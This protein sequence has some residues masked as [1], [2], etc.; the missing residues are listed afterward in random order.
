MQVVV[1]SDEISRRQEKGEPILINQP[2]EGKLFLQ[3]WM[4][5]NVDFVE[6][7]FGSEEDNCVFI[8]GILFAPSTATH[9]VKYLQNLYQADAA[10]L[11]FGKYTFYSAY[12]C[13][14]NSNA[15]PVA[16]AIL[17]GNED[18]IGWSKFW[19]FAKHLHP[20]LD[21]DYV[22]IITDQDKGSKA[23]IVKVLPKAVNFHCSWHRRSNIGKV[24]LDMCITLK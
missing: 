21:D 16:F 3:L 8:V 19:T 23:A 7:H 14:A 5:E 18:T 10:H 22:T 24:S 4:K 17:F 2:A 12:G 9:T 1:L 13:T 11:Q 6:Q 20:E 15:S